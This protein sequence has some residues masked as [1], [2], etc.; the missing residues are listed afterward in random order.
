[1]LKFI[2]T[3]SI[4]IVAAVI[5]LCGAL[6]LERLKAKSKLIYSIPHAFTFLLNNEDK[7]PFNINTASIFINNAGRLAATEVE[8]TFNWKPQNFNIW[9]QRTYTS[10]EDENNRFT[11][12]FSYIA[13]KEHF[14]IELIAEGALPSLLNVRSKEGLATKVNAIPMIVMPLW[15]VYLFRV[16]NFVGYATIIYA[17]LATITSIIK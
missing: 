11:L 9:P 4:Q 8:L 17:V 12:Q 6:V 15:R 10:I 16:I 7:K 1:M 5:S 13:P 3:F 14:S 2:E